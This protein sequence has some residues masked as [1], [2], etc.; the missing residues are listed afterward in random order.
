MDP[1]TLHPGRIYR[2]SRG[3]GRTCDGAHKQSTAMKSIHQRPI[4]AQSRWQAGYWE[5]DLFVGAAQRS[6]IAIL[7]ERKFRFTV[8]VA[9]PRGHSPNRSGDALIG[10][11]TKLPPPCVRR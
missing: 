2:H 7:V 1:Q 11:F 9:V 4:A 8:L 10:A 6:A 3:P 5:G